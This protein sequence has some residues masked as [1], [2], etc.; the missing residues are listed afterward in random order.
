MRMTCLRT[1]DMVGRSSGWRSD[2]PSAWMWTDWDLFT[3]GQN[4][5]ATTTSLK[6][7]A[8]EIPSPIL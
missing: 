4:M 7:R 8:S 5:V 6:P 2:G 1:S 3:C